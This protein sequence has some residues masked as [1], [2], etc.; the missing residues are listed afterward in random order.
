MWP[1]L[2]VLLRALFVAR[3][4]AATNCIK[5][6]CAV[7][8]HYNVTD[9]DL[10]R[11]ANDAFVLQT[12]CLEPFCSCLTDS[13]LSCSNFTHFSQLNFSATYSQ[14]FQ[15]VELRPKQPC[16]LDSKLKLDG[17]NLHGRLNIYNLKMISLFY[18][19]FKQMNYLHK[20][21]LAIF[22]SVFDYAEKCKP[23][24]ASKGNVVFG[25][26]KLDEFRLSNV[27]FAKPVCP[28]MFQDSQIDQFTITNPT[29]NYPSLIL[30]DCN[31]I[32]NLQ[33]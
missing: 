30:F 19:P 1:F 14:I 5:S 2:L 22:D 31:K 4:V 9:Q 11:P 8:Q 24:K 6:H 13:Y 3:L 15:L 7:L 32:S 20:F 18:N 10:A 27:T 12:N 16:K 25:K 28:H 23:A 29:G 21:S 17:L 26:L 33:N